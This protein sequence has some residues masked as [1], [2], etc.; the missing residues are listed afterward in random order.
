M[1]ANN[2]NGANLFLISVIRMTFAILHY[3]YWRITTI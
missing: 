1:N 3:D 2:A